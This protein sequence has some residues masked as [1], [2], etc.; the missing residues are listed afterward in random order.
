M[1]KITKSSAQN[2]ALLCELFAIRFLAKKSTMKEDFLILRTTTV[3]GSVYATRRKRISQAMTL[4]VRTK[5]KPF[6]FI[7]IIIR[8][9]DRI[10]MGSFRCIKITYSYAEQQTI[11]ITNDNLKKL[12]NNY[13]N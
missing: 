6:P 2:V 7:I 4:W 12:M 11:K 1:M 5:M 10:E 8:N 13:D 9:N 3:R